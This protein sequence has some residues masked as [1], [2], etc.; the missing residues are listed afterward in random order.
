MTLRHMKRR[1]PLARVL[2]PAVLSFSWPVQSCIKSASL[3]AS[4]VAGSNCSVAEPHAAADEDL[5]TVDVDK[6]QVSH[7]F[8]NAFR[9]LVGAL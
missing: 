1:Q 2:L 7:F 6:I 4:D 5:G 3:G 8:T 9:Q